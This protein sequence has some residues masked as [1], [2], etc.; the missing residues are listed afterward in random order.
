MAFEA[1]KRWVKDHFADDPQITQRP[2]QVLDRIEQVLP[3][4]PAGHRMQAVE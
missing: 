2:N 1:A 4:I 3:E